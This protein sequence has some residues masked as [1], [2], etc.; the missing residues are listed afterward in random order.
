MWPDQVEGALAELAQKQMEL[1]RREKEMEDIQSEMVKSSRVAV[2]KEDSRRT[3][4]PDAQE[5]IDVD[6]PPVAVADSCLPNKAPCV[7]T[8]DGDGS[9]FAVEVSKASSGA[10]EWIEYWD[11]SAGASYFYNAVTKVKFKKA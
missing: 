8:D 9:P 4:H 10:D 6:S 5:N 2:E 3:E 1:E 11:E 7:T